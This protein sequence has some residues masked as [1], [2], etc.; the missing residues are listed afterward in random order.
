MSSFDNYLKSIGEVGHV[1]SANSVLVYC[2]GLEGAR[3]GEKV[4]FEE[5]QMGLVFAIGRELTE[6]L[7]LDSINVQLGSV[8][9]RTG[10]TLMVEASGDL[11]GKVLDPFGVPIEGQSG[12]GP[13]EARLA[14][15]G[16]GQ[17]GK[18]VSKRYLESPAPPM[19]DRVRIN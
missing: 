12:K 7:L 1:Q 17:S 11:L 18:K 2:S 5:N 8:A 10:E 16:R 19:I 15:G 3:I 9:V 6:V 14:K 13:P 4:F